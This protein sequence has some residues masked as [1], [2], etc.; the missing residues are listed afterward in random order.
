M[1]IKF[2]IKKSNLDE[3]ILAL[4]QDRPPMQANK[5]NE[6]VAFSLFAD[7]LKK[8]LQKQ[9]NKS[10]V[11]DSKPFTIAFRYSEAAVLC[12][13]LDRV[14]TNNILR[15]SICLNLKNKIHRQLI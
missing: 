13:E 6:K 3:L 5:I 12:S 15:A 8:L 2:K 9:I 1:Q 14:K 11:F 4:Q 10:D 7:M